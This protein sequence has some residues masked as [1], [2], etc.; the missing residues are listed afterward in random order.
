MIRVI[1]ELSGNHNQ[2][3]DRALAVVD[4]MADAGVSALKLQTYTPDTMTIDAVGPGFQIQHEGS[5]WKGA[6]LYTLYQQAMTPWEWHAPI[7]ERCRTR[8]IMGFSS[9]F[10]PTAVAFLESLDV[11][12]YKIASFENTDI[13]LLRSVGKT[14]KPVI[15]STGMASMREIAEAVETLD[16]AGCPE[17]TLLKC[18]S[19]YPADP[20][21]CHLSTIPHLQSIFPHCRV[22]VS[23]HTLGLGVAVA[24]V[25][26][27]ATVVEKHVTLKRSDGGVDAAFSMEPHEMAQLVKEVQLAQLAIGV[28]TYGPTDHERPSLAFRRSIY[29]V[30]PVTAGTV[31]TPDHIRCIRPG[32]GLPPREWEAVLGKRFT[33][34]A[35]PGTPLTWDL[36]ST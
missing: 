26:L 8:G 32:Y 34:D 31:I 3:L 33:K 20:A 36:L 25:A 15:V 22:G 16:R 4:A 12:M 11:P 29:V 28:P 30:A 13:P 18:T 6:S 5:L 23:D 27:G 10:D 14:G 2:S 7:F 9:P 24:S 19:A 21:H 1:A 35:S 17:I